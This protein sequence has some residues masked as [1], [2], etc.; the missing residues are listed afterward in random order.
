MGKL[1]SDREF[2]IAERLVYMGT[3]KEAAPSLGITERTLET[4]TKNIFRKL[5]ITKLNELVLWYCG[6]TFRITAQIESKKQEVFTLA[7][8]VSPILIAL[9]FTIST[10]L[11]HRE[12][13]R[14]RRY[15]RKT[16][17]EYAI[18]HAPTVTA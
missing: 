14:F 1:L 2:E 7:K 5:T 3:K 17:T 10:T 16:E 8:R 6:E 11:E 4:H 15:R 12:F 13:L 9:I 18:L